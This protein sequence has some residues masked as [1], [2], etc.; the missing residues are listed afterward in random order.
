MRCWTPTVSWMVTLVLA[1]GSFEAYAAGTSAYGYD[2][3]KP[4][5]L[6]KARKRKKK[7]K[8]ADDLSAPPSGDLHAAQEGGT[9]EPYTW[10]V[11]LLSDLTI[12]SSKQGDADAVKTANYVLS[13]QGLRLLTDS[14]EVGA[15]LDYSESTFKT[16]E[17]SDT[18][19]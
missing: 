17:D 19:S 8:K 2:A 15:G 4:V 13:G 16:K 7:K 12:D 5:L 1:A 3:E 10:E 9:D 6:A 18:S 14:I 11:T